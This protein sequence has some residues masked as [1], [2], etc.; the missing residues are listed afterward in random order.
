M[1]G[2]LTKE[3]FYHSNEEN[4]K[5]ANVKVHVQKKGFQMK[6]LEVVNHLVKER[7]FCHWMMKIMEVIRS[8]EAQ[9]EQEPVT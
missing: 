6:Y 3:I 9:S 1:L 4:Y 8:T 5:W 2:I 7:L